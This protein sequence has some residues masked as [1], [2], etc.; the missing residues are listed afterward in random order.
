MST[1]S[2]TPAANGS[3][4][5]RW[6]PLLLVALG[7]YL[8]RAHGSDGLLGILCGLALIAQVLVTARRPVDS[9]SP[10]GRLVMHWK[11]ILIALGVLAVVG[12]TLDAAGAW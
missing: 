8:H 7:I 11:G 5:L 10:V 1:E 2:H 3:T 12:G 4:L 9:L 6:L